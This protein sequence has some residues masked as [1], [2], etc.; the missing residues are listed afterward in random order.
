MDREEFEFILDRACLQFEPDDPEYHR[1]TKEVYSYVNKLK[2]FDALRST[3]HFGP[4]AFY[5]VWNNDIHILLMDTIESGNIEEAGALIRLYHL[6]Y[7][8][9]KSAES[10]EPIEDDV[11]LIK[12]YAELDSLDRYELTGAIK[13]YEKLQKEKQEINIGIKK[14]HGLINNENGNQ[15][16]KT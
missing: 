9:T 16:P 1:I 10:I 11:E 12:R 2:K 14:A 3:R 8:E 13:K 7:P 4:L 5:L 6:V 15:K